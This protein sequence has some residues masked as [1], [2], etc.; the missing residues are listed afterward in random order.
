MV[1]IPVERTCG[2]CRHDGV[3]IGGRNV[4]CRGTPMSPAA[5]RAC[6]FSHFIRAGS[7]IRSFLD[8]DLGCADRDVSA[9]G[10]E[11]RSP[12]C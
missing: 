2:R 1:R 5:G 12:C 9:S 8:G 4:G 10:H 3:L 11:G 7:L 6:L